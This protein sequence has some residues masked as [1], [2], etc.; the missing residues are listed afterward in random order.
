MV[1]MA[2]EPWRRKRGA[3][4]TMGFDRCTVRPKSPADERQLALFFF[5]LLLLVVTPLSSAVLYQAPKKAFS[6][7]RRKVFHALLMG[8]T[9]TER[10]SYSRWELPRPA[11]AFLSLKSREYHSQVEMSMLR[12][13]MQS[14][15]A[16]ATTTG[17]GSSVGCPRSPP[18]AP[19]AAVMMWF[20][21]FLS[22]ASNKLG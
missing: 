8:K 20:Y 5:L 14:H 2:P 4:V 7:S 15:L 16:H 3:M 13:L 17:I 1:P 21:F 11:F 6:S 9:F 10:D 18:T 19:R 12:Y 22:H